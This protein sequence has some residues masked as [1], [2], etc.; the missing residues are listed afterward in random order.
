MEANTGAQILDLLKAGDHKSKNQALKIIFNRFG[1]RLRWF[2]IRR[3]ATE[4]DSEDLISEVILSIFRSHDKC[5]GN[6]EPWLWT[7]ARNEFYDYGRAKKKSKETDDDI[8]NIIDAADADEFADLL[9][10]EAFDELQQAQLIDCVRKGLGEYGDRHPERA[11]ILQWYYM[12]EMSIAEI[13]ALLNRSKEAI[14]QVL[15]QTR[16]QVQPYLLK[17][18]GESP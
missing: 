5:H 2:F 12:D 18:A 1:S 17:C 13:A 7:I 6:F 10:L 11:Q 4:A 3:G 14:K 8:D 16:Q 9:S 15:F